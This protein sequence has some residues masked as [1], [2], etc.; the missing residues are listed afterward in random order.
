VVEKTM[1]IGGL[2]ILGS[3][4]AIAVSLLGASWVADKTATRNDTS[5]LSALTSKISSDERFRNVQ[6]EVAGSVVSLKGTVRLVQDRR[7]LVRAASQTAHVRSIND[8]LS[9]NTVWT[10]DRLLRKELYEKLQNEQIDGVGL[11][12]KKGIVNVRGEVQTQADRDHVLRII[13]TTEG[14]R[15]IV[16]RMTV[17]ARRQAAREHPPAAPH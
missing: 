12:V 14:V 3:F 8:Q 15:E 6:I 4:A 10:P 1:G 7:D 2:K 11:K 17:R 9:V 5:I 16:D 13:S